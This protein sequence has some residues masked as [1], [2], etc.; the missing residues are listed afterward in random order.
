MARARLLKPGFFHNEDLAEVPAFG[1]LLFAGLWTIADR[2]GRLDDR[3]KR[4]KAEL[5][6]YDNVNVPDLLDKLEIA[7]FI[8]RYQIE[9]VHFIQV[10]AFTK[11]QS[12]HVREPA[13]TIP[14]PDEH[15]ASTGKAGTGPAV[16][17]T[18]IDPIAETETVNARH[19]GAASLAGR[20][21]T[22]AEVEV[23]LPDLALKY[24]DIDVPREYEAACDWLAAEN[25]R[26]ADYLAF[27][28]NWLRR[29]QNERPTNQRANAFATPAEQRDPYRLGERELV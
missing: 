2:E 11:H 23:H 18:V 12:P 25:K 13:S 1:R 27:F 10:L 7:G 15:S 19:G 22:I 5:F 20:C 26:K 8:Q 24:P 29:K 6:P 9:N 16:A 17:E 3:P 4:I 21:K 28:R 14:A